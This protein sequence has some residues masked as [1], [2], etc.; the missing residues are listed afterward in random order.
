[1]TI[2]RTAA[3]L[4]AALVVAGGLTAGVAG[5]SAAACKLTAGTPFHHS[6]NIKANVSTSGCSTAI[7]YTA[8]LQWRNLTGV[9]WTNLDSGTWRGNESQTLL[10]D[11]K[12]GEKETYRAIVD[13]SNGTSEYSAEKTFTCGQ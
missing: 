12:A 6:G 13:G 4:T 3:V 8:K 9:A 1:M 7:T 10:F 11:C 2:T 5:A